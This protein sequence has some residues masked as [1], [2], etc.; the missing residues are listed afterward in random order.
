MENKIIEV[1]SI[2]KEKLIKK[3]SYI[4][5]KISKD[6][7][8][9]KFVFKI[10]H[11]I[12]F[13]ILILFFALLIAESALPGIFSAAISFTKIIFFIF[14]VL[15]IIYCLGI[16]KINLEDKGA[17]RINF[18]MKIIF[19]ILITVFLANALLKFMIWQN[20][21]ITAVSVAL[22][23]FFYKLLLEKKANS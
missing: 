8:F 10:L 17:F 16:K 14:S 18:A 5:A 23:Y 3:I 7:N 11:D 22:F 20:I 12:L 1:S 9:W 21:I 15:G 4:A 2:K 19:L 13:L 6:E